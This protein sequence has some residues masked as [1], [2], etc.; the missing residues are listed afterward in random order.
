M[1]R[2]KADNPSLCCCV[3]SLEIVMDVVTRTYRTFE[4]AR[5]VAL[6]LE[7]AGVPVDRISL[8]GRHRTGD[9]QAAQGAAIGGLAGGAAG[10]LA[11]LGMVTIPGLGPVVAIGWLASTVVG[12]GTAAAAGGALGAVT[13]SQAEA[14]QQSSYSEAL[15]R[16]EAVV[17]VRTEGGEAARITAILDE[18]LPVEPADADDAADGGPSAGDLSRSVS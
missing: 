15:R 12:A 1:S 6:R 5:N 16:G 7:A 3:N 8:V 13:G 18:G 4:D 11:G 14:E 2:A 10:L 9:D 17:A